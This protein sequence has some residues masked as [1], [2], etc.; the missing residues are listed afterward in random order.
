VC[1]TLIYTYAE[2]ADR[3]V[4]GE[5]AHGPVHNVNG[6]GEPVGN[7]GAPGTWGEPDMGGLVYF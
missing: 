2:N 5:G 4:R 1:S 3:R 7:D 6:Q